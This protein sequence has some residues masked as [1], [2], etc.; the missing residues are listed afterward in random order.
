MGLDYVEFVMDLEDTFDIKLDDKHFSAVR[1]PRDLAIIIRDQLA[2]EGRIWDESNAFR[3]SSNLNWTMLPEFRMWTQLKSS[4]P[5]SFHRLRPNTCLDKLLRAPRL[6]S[7]WQQWQTQAGIP[8]PELQNP[9]TDGAAWLALII[10][11]MLIWPAYVVGGA[12]G[13]SVYLLGSA[14]F[15]FTVYCISQGVAS[16]KT[17]LPTG[18]V[19]IGDLVRTVVPESDRWLWSHK[20]LKFRAENGF[21]DTPSWPLDSIETRVLKVLCE[22][23]GLAQGSISSSENLTELFA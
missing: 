13:L 8:L 20:T 23:L 1:T 7:L 21:G 17:M 14:S 4:L 16:S 3:K 18:C 10:L 11:L 9:S 6:K 5:V 15:V 2:A 12:L 19:T 22:N